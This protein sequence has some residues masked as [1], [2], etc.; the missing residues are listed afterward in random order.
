MKVTTW[1]GIEAL[2]K[3]LDKSLMIEIKAYFKEFVTIHLKERDYKNYNLSDI[4]RIAI[5]EKSDNINHLSQLGMTQRTMTLTQFIPEFV[6]PIKVG[7][8]DYY[9]ITV[10]LNDNEGIVLFVSKQIV[11][12]ELRRWIKKWQ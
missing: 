12:G 4:A 6:D 5:L 1:Q 11:K 10:L 3:I 8:E 7:K 2:E 9:R